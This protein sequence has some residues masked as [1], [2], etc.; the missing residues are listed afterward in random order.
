[1]ARRRPRDEDDEY[2]LEGRRSPRPPRPRNVIEYVVEVFTFTI[3]AMLLILLVG[4]IVIAFFRPE[5]NL[6]GV[7]N[8][9]TD[10]MT[11]MLG[12]LIGYIAGRGN[13]PEDE[14]QPPVPPPRVPRP[15]T[16]PE[17]VDEP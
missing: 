14:G 11:T 6:S 15:P 10:I 13:R 12:A 5:A 7:F 9:I 1:V 8:A 17:E 4:A 2:Q 16:M 3:A